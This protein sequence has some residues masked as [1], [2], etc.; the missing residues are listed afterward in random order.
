MNRSQSGVF[1]R[2]SLYDIANTRIEVRLTN[3]CKGFYRRRLQN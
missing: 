3:I 1:G 2:V